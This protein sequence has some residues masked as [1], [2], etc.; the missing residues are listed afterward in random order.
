MDSDNTKDIEEKQEELA[1]PEEA[2]Q[3]A[4]ELD[5]DVAVGQTVYG[6]ELTAPELIHLRD[7]FSIISPDASSTLSQKLSLANGMGVHEAKLWRKICTAC[8]NAGI[9]V[10]ST[11]PDYLA[12]DVSQPKIDIFPLN[13][14]E[15]TTL[16]NKK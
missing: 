14:G 2:D 13:R 11:A 10:G 1:P 5:I 12:T 3:P 4:E 6:L 15:V 7:L 16:G 9:P 8:I